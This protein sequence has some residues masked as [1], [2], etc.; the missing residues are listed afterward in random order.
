MGH[1]LIHDWWVQFYL[2]YVAVLLVAVIW[3]DFLRYRPADSQPPRNEIA[4]LAAG[5]VHSA[6]SQN[7][8]R[9]ISR[10]GRWKY[11]EFEPNRGLRANQAPT[12]RELMKKEGVS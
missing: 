5:S 12:N 7:S 6:A 8:V 10:S 2:L 1:L 4:T 3:D 11:P 9:S